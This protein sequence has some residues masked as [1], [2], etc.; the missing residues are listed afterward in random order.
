MSTPCE[1]LGY[2]EGQAFTLLTDE[3]SEFD[4]GDTIYLHNDDNSSNPE[5]RDTEEYDEDDSSCEYIY[6][7]HVAPYDVDKTPCESLGYKEGDLFIVNEDCE[8]DEGSI[9][10]LTSDDGS[11]CPYFVLHD[12]EDRGD[13]PYL[14]HIQPL[15]PQVGRKARIRINRTSGHPAGTE[16][17]ITNVYD[18]SVTIEYK[19]VRMDHPIVDIV[20][21]AFADNESMPESGEPEW[22]VTEPHRWN[23][24]DLAIVRRTDGS[25]CFDRYELISFNGDYS[26]GHGGFTNSGGTL[27]SVEFKTL[28]RIPHPERHNEVEFR[29]ERNSEVVPIIKAIRRL[30]GWGLKDSKDVFDEAKATGEWKTLGVFFEKDAWVFYAEVTDAKG[31]VSLSDTDEPLSNAKPVS[32]PATWP[33][34]PKDEW[35]EGDK[36]IVRGQQSYDEHNFPIGS[37]VTFMH[38]HNHERGRFESPSYHRSQTVDYELIEPIQTGSISFET[39]VDAAKQFLGDE[40]ASSKPRQVLYY[41]DGD[42]KEMTLIGYFQSKPVLGYVDRWD[43]PQV[44]IGKESLMTEID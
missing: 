31:D 3:Y 25:H 9:I 18:S 39:L 35:K 5:F 44:F 7:H 12:N 24:G 1:K 42:S 21:F 2:T 10:R 13:Y 40:M 4:A 26:G 20:T 37:E 38:G 30:T 27:Q 14:S 32:N 33:T 41:Q 36:G 43:D 17:T 28:E 11:V 29:V 15:Q 6:L 19:G 8:Y 34:K 22:D 16:G 23:K